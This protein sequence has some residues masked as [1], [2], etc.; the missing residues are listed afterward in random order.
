MKRWFLYAIALTLLLAIGLGKLGFYDPRFVH[1]DDIVIKKPLFYL[2]SAENPSIVLSN[3][4]TTSLIFPSNIISNVALYTIYKTTDPKLYR[5]HL[6]AALDLET[7]TPNV[8]DC[9]LS[10]ELFKIGNVDA[11]IHPIQLIDI[12]KYPYEVSFT[13]ISDERESNMIRQIC[14]NSNIL[15]VKRRQSTPAHEEILKAI[16]IK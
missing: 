2:N 9:Y 14:R 4:D 15:E 11:G 12:H 8:N 16:T 13:E 3:N 5:F 6:L 7:N 10:K 1:V